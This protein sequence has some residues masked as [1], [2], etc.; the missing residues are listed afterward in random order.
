VSSSGLTARAPV[1]MPR[2][3]WAGVE[4]RPR[5]IVARAL[6]YLGVAGVTASLRFL[7]LVGFS[8]DHYVSLA[9]AQQMLL[10]DWPTRDFLDP[11]L[12]LMYAASAG[13]QLMLGRNLFAE[14]MLVC[15]AFGIGASL[16]VIAVRQLTG[17]LLSGIAAA[18]FEVAIVPFTYS[19][20]KILLYAAG[21]LIMWWY[22][23]RPSIGRMAGLAA[24][25]SVAFLFRHD[26][27]V[28]LGCGA[29]LAVAFASGDGMHR[30][31]GTRIGVMTALTMAAVLPYL[32]YLSV[33]GGVFT[34]FERGL[35]FSASE[36]ERTT[37]MTP[38]F[39]AAAGLER[40]STAFLYYLFRLLPLAAA[41]VLIAQLRE[42]RW[43]STMAKVAPL[44]VV[45][46]LVNRGFLRE[47]LSDRLADA[48]VPAVL[49]AAWLIASGYQFFRRGRA[50]IGVAATMVVGMSA[51]AVGQVGHTAE[52]LN[53]ASVFGGVRRLP[54]RFI[55]RANE[56]H[57]RFAARQMPA[58]PV[59]ALIPFFEYA[60]RCTT[61]EHRLLLPGFIPEVAVYAQ[62]PFAGG[63][64]SFF[65]GIFT[66]AED[67][68][69]TKRRLA[70]EL[71]P[72]AVVS[73]TWRE[74][75]PSY[76]SAFIA[77]RFEP[78][79]S[80]QFRGGSADVLIN[81]EITPVRRDAATGWPCFR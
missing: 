9:G 16:T 29:A 28:Y 34:H 22:A 68:A 6:L 58:G 8:N 14:A 74:S 71:V 39:S 35:A 62:R 38:A 60:D 54:E 48:I 7:G 55:D 79:T 47:T 10:G 64:S 73:S 36:A 27:G 57:D 78:V 13:A 43:R 15:C 51:V 32:I 49:L 66:S 59:S 30:R 56:L 24:F 33:N 1:M 72:I 50:V 80:Y 76:S 65:P 77:A 81:R 46:L 26:H 42:P 75:M 18:S 53:R 25:I 3:P 2:V 41:V 40:N 12:P 52:Q 67:Q 19:Y 31:F 37:L 61:T 17:S 21:P 5:A 23:R 70:Q 45:A 20:P 44:V 69:F 11:G 4:S 63:R